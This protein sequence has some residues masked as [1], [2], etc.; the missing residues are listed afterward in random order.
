M[1]QY[2]W[3]PL[4]CLAIRELETILFAQ[5]MT[6]VSS[7]DLY[8]HHTKAIKGTAKSFPQC[9]EE[10]SGTPTAW[11]NPTAES[12]EKQKKRKL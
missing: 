4:K 8:V 2:P 12:P 1:S 3:W 5:K 9:Q 7:R 6:L 10:S 11:F